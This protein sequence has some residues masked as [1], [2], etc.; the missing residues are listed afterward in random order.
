MVFPSKIHAG[1]FIQWRD[2]ATNDAFGNPINSP[3]WS[4]IY[5]LR[6]NRSN[7]GATIQSTAFGDGFQFEIS[8]AVTS[9]FLEGNWFYEAKANKSGQQ[10]IQTI[11]TGKFEVLPSLAFTGNNPKA[12]D[13][14]T[15]TKKTLDLI[16]AA[17]NDV[18]KNGAVQ[19]YK[20]GTRS[21][22]KYELSELYVLRSKYLAQVK[23][24]EQAEMM[25]NGLGNPRR[26]YVRFM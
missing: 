5:Y 15:E 14:R 13:G 6:T 11:S 23:L 20:I 26:M 1:D 3:D 16:E 8:S 25:A 2:N 18:I 24:E 4:V 9:T 21:A 22:K 19:E 12:F 7:F 17:I 10:L